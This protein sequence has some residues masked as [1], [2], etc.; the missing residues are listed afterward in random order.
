MASKFFKSRIEAQAV[1][2]RTKNGLSV[3]EAVNLE[4][5]LLYLNIITIF[6][7]LDNVSGMAL[8]LST[9]RSSKRFMLINSNH[10]VGR[11][12]FTICHELYHLFIQQ[13]F[14]YQICQTGLFDAKKDI[15]EYKA[16]I[17]ASYFLM[18]E[19]GIFNLI[20]DIELDNNTV[21]LSTI[22][23]IEHYFSCSRTAL[24]IRLKDLGLLSEDRLNAFRQNIKLS[25]YQH[26]YDNGLYEPTLANHIIGDYGEKVKK[27][28]DNET[29]SESHYATL[30]EDIGINIYQIFKTENDI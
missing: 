14:N 23:K 19:S 22:L 9:D 26:G 24:L 25:A 7:P 13:N 20:P 29:I 6:R 3:H 10:S 11:Q 1:D 4:S 18:P 17:F 2:F 8:K 12:N 28:Y 21:S 16:D 27:L 15:E 30:M 5:L